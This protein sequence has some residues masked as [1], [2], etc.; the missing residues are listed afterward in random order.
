MSNNNNALEVIK[1]YMQN[2]S[3][4]QRIQEMLGERSGAFCNSLINVV[5]NSSMLQK[6]SPD[7]VMAAAMEA[8]SMDLPINPSLGYAA[9]VPYQKGKNVFVA[10]YQLMFK[11]RI[12][13]CIRTGQYRRIFDNEIYSDE[14]KVHNPITGEIEFNDPSD[15]KLRDSGCPGD[16]VGFYA[17]FQLITGFECSV[18]L[19]KERAYAHAE[20]YSKS[21]QKDLRENTKKSLWFTDPISMGKKT[22]LI[23]LLSR[24][25]ISSVEMCN[26]MDA[27]DC[28]VSY[29]QAQEMASQ[30]VAEQAGSE[31]VEMPGNE[32]RESE[33]NSN[34]TEDGVPEFMK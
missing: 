18:Y 8:A 12:Q 1:G 5:K 29:S 30:V 21:Y 33:S 25:G 15:C 3:V 6:C 23:M 22:A 31:V 17:M 24:Y 16:V 14:L 4:K 26:T 13:L 11:G 9:I 20:K 7:T 28:E 2:D 34:I 27:E 19:S 10:N 32:S